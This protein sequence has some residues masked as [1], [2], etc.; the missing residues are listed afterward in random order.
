MDVSAHLPERGEVGV[1]LRLVERR[2]LDPVNGVGSE[3]D[4]FSGLVSY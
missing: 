1:D 4:R 2:I 3:R